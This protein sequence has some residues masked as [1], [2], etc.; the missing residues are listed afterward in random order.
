MTTEIAFGM[1]LGGIIG[2]LIN[3]T[4]I[5]GQIS[6]TLKSNGESLSKIAKHF[7][8]TDEKDKD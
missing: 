1:L 6:K 2:M 7:E 4:I 3:I 8:Q 5:L